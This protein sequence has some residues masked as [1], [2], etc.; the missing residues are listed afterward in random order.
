MAS[1]LKK[2]FSRKK[3]K[4]HHDNADT[5]RADNTDDRPTFRT[6]LY[7]TAPAATAPETG[8]YPIKGDHNTPALAGRRGSSRSRRYNPN[9][10]TDMPLPPMPP[11]QQQ[12]GV[13]HTPMN[14][15]ANTGGLRMV[16]DESNLSDNL[17]NLRLHEPT[18][19]YQMCLWAVGSF[20]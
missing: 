15:S 14:P 6:S 1:R 8:G 10:K 9:S 11:S 5:S 18:G 12:T 7:H 3:D 19:Q 17:S 2:I 20:D 16:Q 4:P 13:R